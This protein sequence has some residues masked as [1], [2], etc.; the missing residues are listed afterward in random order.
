MSGS[1]PDERSIKPNALRYGA[2]ILTKRF[3]MSLA[4]HNEPLAGPLHAEKRRF[5]LQIPSVAA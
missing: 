2:G 1:I 5:Y 3:F 4:R